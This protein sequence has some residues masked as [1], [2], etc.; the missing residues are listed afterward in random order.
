MKKQQKS[1]PILLAVLVCAISASQ[2]ASG[3]TYGVSQKI[4]VPGDGGWDYLTA[5]AATRRLYISHGTQVDVLDM[6]QAK[7]VGHIANTPGVHGIALSPDRGFISNGKE[8]TLAIFDPLTLAV[9]SRVNVGDNPDAI[10]YDPASTHVFTF[11][12]RSH[13]TTAVDPATGLVVGRL[14]LGGKPEFAVADGSGM[15]YDNLEDQSQLVAI[16]AKA[17]TVKARWPLAP[18]EEPSS[19]A[20]DNA[21]RRL[22]AGCGNHQMA[23][24]DAD[25]GHVITTLPIG[26]HADATV[27]DPGTGLIF[28]SNG[29][30]TLTIIHEDSPNAYHVVENVATQ[31][32]A[33]TVA[34]DLKTH[35]LFLATA[36]FGPA[37]AATAQQPHP[38]PAIIPG[39]FTILVVGT[40]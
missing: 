34:L 16:D 36:Q 25:S 35:R 8:G 12:G 17:L 30:G 19:L 24:I 28:N 18:C 26:N 1:L 9:L 29:D 4:A 23:V 32:G 31:K 13:D 3:N 40:K 6:D 21:H 22:F 14:P 37:P 27:F 39:T 20:I 33:R 11:N 10:L 5:D 7:V 2:A 15:I 38:R